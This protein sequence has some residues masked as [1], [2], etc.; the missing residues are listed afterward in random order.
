[1]VGNIYLLNIFCLV[2]SILHL[3]VFLSSFFPVNTRAHMKA[4]GPEFI[5]GLE[6]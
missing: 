4:E 1:M 6:S 5:L 3:L 2:F